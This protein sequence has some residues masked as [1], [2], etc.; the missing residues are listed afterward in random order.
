[1]YLLWPGLLTTSLSLRD[2]LNQ[3]IFAVPHIRFFLNIHTTPAYTIHMGTIVSH[4]MQFKY[5]DQPNCP[6]QTLE[7]VF[8][9]QPVVE[10][11]VE[12]VE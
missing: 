11:M 6:N 2:T 5:I 4:N 10:L 1:M 9:L 8:D 12:I 7:I 3:A